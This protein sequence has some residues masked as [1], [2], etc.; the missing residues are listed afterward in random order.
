M[1]GNFHFP[2]LPQAHL[3]SNSPGDQN[4]YPGEK[5]AS[6]L[7]QTGGTLSCSAVSESN[8]GITTA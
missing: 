6:S 4:Y 1:M 7:K 2:F 3:L 8:D 5:N